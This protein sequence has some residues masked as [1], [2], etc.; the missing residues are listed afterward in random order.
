MNN[1]WNSSNWG[2]PNSSIGPQ[3]RTPVITGREAAEMYRLGPDSNVILMDHSGK[4]VWIVATDS[5][6]YRSIEPY[7]LIP[8]KEPEP[9]DYNSILTRMNKMEELLSGLVSTI[10]GAGTAN[11]TSSAPN[12]ADPSSNSNSDFSKQF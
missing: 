4:M 6:G 9:P 5:A 1:N 10:N 3:Q 2:Y 7:D 12:S 8:H 11:G